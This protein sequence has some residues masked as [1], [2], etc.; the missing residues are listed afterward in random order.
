MRQVKPHPKTSEMMEQYAHL[1][2][3]YDPKTRHIFEPPAVV[4]LSTRGYPTC[5]SNLP[6][7]EQ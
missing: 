6:G 2:P 5:C 4:R 3:R 1:M 7:K